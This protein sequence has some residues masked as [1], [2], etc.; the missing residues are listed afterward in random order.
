MAAKVVIKGPY[1][2]RYKSA[3]FLKM[4]ALGLVW[5][6]ALA[7]LTVAL[8]GYTFGAGIIVMVISTVFGEIMDLHWDEIWMEE[9]NIK[10][11][12]TK[13]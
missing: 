5:A 7:F 6:L 8:L 1:W 11:Q 4:F 12:I 3:K 2:A 9:N 10:V 13:E